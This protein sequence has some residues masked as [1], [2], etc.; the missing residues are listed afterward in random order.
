MYNVESKELTCVAFK[1]PESQWPPNDT[2]SQPDQLN[3][4]SSVCY[5]FD[6]EQPLTDSF[7]AYNEQGREY[8][9]VMDVLYIISQEIPAS[10][11]ERHLPQLSR[12][13]GAIRD[14][15]TIRAS[16]VKA[17]KQHFT[18]VVDGADETAKERNLQIDCV[19][20][21]A[22]ATWGKKIKDFAKRTLQSV[23]PNHCDVVF[24]AHSEALAR[25]LR[26]C[27]WDKLDKFLQEQ[28]STVLVNVVDFSDHVVVSAYLCILSSKHS[29]A[30]LNWGDE[31]SF[32]SSCDMKYRRGNPA[33][34]AP[35]PSD[36]RA[37][38][39]LS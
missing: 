3:E 33:D 25:C 10:Q 27:V 15:H 24:Y 39:F 8:T 13:A 34:R 20:V 32:L 35:L 38:L 21:S 7:N 9:T 6:G 19:A 26:M 29:S 17:I 37:H 23:M 14:D 31:D 11:L 28:K 5:V 1:A 22:P 30:M 4:L 18:D 36:I 2:D 16:C 12:L